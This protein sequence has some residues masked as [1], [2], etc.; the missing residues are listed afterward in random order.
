MS[1][2]L[3]IATFQTGTYIVTR[4][5]TDSHTLGVRTVGAPSTFSID[6]SLQPVTGANLKLVP[7][8]R[9]SEDFRMLWTKTAALILTPNPDTIAIGSDTYEVFK[10]FG[11]SILEPTFYRAMIAKQG[12]PG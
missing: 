9:R 12:V 6:A 4:T 11:F 5:G 1:L 7:Q 8:G 3:V 10:T 2:G